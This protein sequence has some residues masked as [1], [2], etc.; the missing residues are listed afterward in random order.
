LMFL[1]L[2][3]EFVGVW[4]YVR[5]LV[6]PLHQSI[7]HNVSR[8]VLLSV[9]GAIALGAIC[10]LAYRVRARAPLVSFGVAW[11]LL[12]LV[13]TSTVFPL[14]HMVAEHRVYLTSVGFFLIVGTLLAWLDQRLR[15]RP[16]GLLVALS[17]AG[18]LALVGLGSLTMS[19]IVVWSDPVMLWREAAITA[20]RWDTLTGLGNALRD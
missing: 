20:P 9:L 8:L 19:R 7:A 3:F 10:I 6:L 11:F 13:P 16:G 17:A 4:T 15:W 12:L 14:E 5:L 2:K 1:Y 18:I